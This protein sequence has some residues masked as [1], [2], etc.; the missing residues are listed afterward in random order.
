MTSTSRRLGL[1]VCSAGM[2]LSELP[3]TCTDA[4]RDQACAGALAVGI[5]HG[6]LLLWSVSD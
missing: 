6:A 3:L 2:S 1:C 4:N 5:R